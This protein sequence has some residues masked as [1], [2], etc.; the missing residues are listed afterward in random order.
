MQAGSV[1]T[2][3]WS[4]AKPPSTQFIATLAVQ[5]LAQSQPLAHGI[6]TWRGA[7]AMTRFLVYLRSG[8]ESTAQ[9]FMHLWQMCSS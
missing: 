3:I 7:I 9:H 8:P 5:L 6:K 4:W 1:D 2:V